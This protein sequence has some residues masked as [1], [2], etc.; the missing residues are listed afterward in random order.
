MRNFAKKQKK[1]WRWEITSENGWTRENQELSNPNT[2]VYLPNDR[3]SWGIL[4]GISG[5][6]VALMS[7][8]LL[9]MGALCDWQI[10]MSFS[11][12]VSAWPCVDA[13][14]SVILSVAVWSAYYDGAIVFLRLGL[15]AKRCEGGGSNVRKA[16][17]TFRY[18]KSF[19]DFWRCSIPLMTK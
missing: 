6:D 3:R 11:I 2:I 1:T 7:L 5:F 13:F 9:V 14:S 19:S 18:L 17:A 16:P 4:L 10:S 15:G 12:I 8:V